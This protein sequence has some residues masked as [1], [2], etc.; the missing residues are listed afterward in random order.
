VIE[1]LR[2]SLAVALV[3]LIATVGGATS[4]QD[5]ENK[6]KKKPHRS[7]PG[8]SVRV[9]GTRHYQGVFGKKSRQVRA[10][11]GIFSALPD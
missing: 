9:T 2:V 3:P 6:R 8:D 10:D 1:A 5:Y 11:G 7:S 4:H